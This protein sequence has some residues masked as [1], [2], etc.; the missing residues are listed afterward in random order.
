MSENA[1][2]HHKMTVQPHPTQPAAFL[3]GC[4]FSWGQNTQHNGVTVDVPVLVKTLSGFWKIYRARQ[5]IEAV[6]RGS[7]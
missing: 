3:C 5:S 1:M 4:T 2:P 6:H 7:P